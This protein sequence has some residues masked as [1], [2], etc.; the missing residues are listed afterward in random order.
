[1]AKPILIDL[2]CGAGGATKGYQDAGFYVVGVDINPQPRYIG[3]EFI[4]ADVMDYINT[5]GWWVDFDAIHASPPCQAFS[6]STPSERRHLHPDYIAGVRYVLAASP[7]HY[8]IENVPQAPLLNPIILCGSMFGLKVRR[9]R[10]FESSLVLTT[11]PCRHK[12]QGQPVGVY[13]GGTGTGQQRGRKVMHNH[14]AM[15]VME[16]PW[17]NRK[18]C[19]EAIP[20]RYTEFLGRQLIERIRG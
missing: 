6:V 18:E 19:N 17:A 5:R 3:D 9:H 11:L 12:E 14:E 4:Q 10:K 8:I 16:M 1:M 15:E 7:L 13:G 2:F 20:P